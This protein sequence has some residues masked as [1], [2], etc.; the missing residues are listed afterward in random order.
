MDDILKKVF[1]TSL[2]DII[3]EMYDVH[4]PRGVNQDEIEQDYN[5]PVKM[6][7]G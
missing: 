1:R 2:S 5:F 4:D 6:T 7:A 3:N